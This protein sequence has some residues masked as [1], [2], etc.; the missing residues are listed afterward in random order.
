MSPPLAEV[1][2]GEF[3]MGPIA[4]GPGGLARI[5][6]KVKI[7]EPHV[8]RNLG[9]TITF[10]I[11]IPLAIDMVVDLRLDKQKFTVDG[12]IALRAT[13]R[14]AEP[15]LLVIDLANHASDISVHVTSKSVRG[16]ILRIVAGV[17]TEIRRFIAAY[18]ADE[19]DSPAS[20][21][22]DHRRRPRTRRDLGRAEL[23]Q[24]QPGQDQGF[25]DRAQLVEQV[26]DSSAGHLGAPLRQPAGQMDR[27]RAQF[28]IG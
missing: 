16:E 18:V 17:D 1:A 19:I 26:L 12:D 4:Q 25:S 27:V 22:Q 21:G 7:Q 5:S 13:A 15:L 8:R 2:G 10:S 23:S 20:E 3:E 28:E 6:A 11:R 9:D 14:A 24:P